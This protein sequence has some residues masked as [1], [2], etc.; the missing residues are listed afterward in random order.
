MQRAGSPLAGRAVASESP[1]RPGNFLHQSSPGAVRRPPDRSHP[2]ASPLP[3]PL[4]PRAQSGIDVS[5][6]L[7][8]LYED[9]KLRKKHK[10]FV[11]SL[12]KTG[13]VGVKATFDWS[14]D[15]KAEPAS[16]DKNKDSFIELVKNLPTDDAR[17]VVFDFTE[18][19]DDGR[20]IKKLILIKWCPDAVNFRLKPVIGATYQTLK[21]KLSGLGKDIQAV[22]PSDLDYAVVAVSRAQRD[23]AAGLGVPHLKPHT[24]LTSRLPSPPFL[25]PHFLPEMCRSSSRKGPT[26]M[27]SSGMGVPRGRLPRERLGVGCVGVGSR[28]AREMREE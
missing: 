19:K 25:P 9:V 18:T 17:F 21:E 7:I 28:G 2:P 12:K 1:V 13:Q 4:P 23:E 8:T 20:Q 5:D 11:F 22:D 15:H 14:I 24:P 10:Y 27:P 26:L 16:D 6:E 3:I